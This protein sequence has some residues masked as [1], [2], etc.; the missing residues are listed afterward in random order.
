M[1]DESAS[2]ELAARLAAAL[3]PGDLVLLEGSLGAGKTFLCREILYA[4]GL[5]EQEPVT[6]PTFALLHEYP[7]SPPVLH[8]D[9]YRLG[10]A[11]ELLELGL[12]EQ[13]GGEAIVLLEWAERFAD[14]LGPIALRIELEMRGEEARLARLSSGSPR[15]A[16]L[17]ASLASG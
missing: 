15:G 16:E 8:G 9:L 10:H 5:P 11:D 4:L 1:P 7:T 13:L 12:L 14:A 17:L 3:S 2:R 6:S